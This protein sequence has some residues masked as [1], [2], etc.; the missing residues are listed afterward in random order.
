MKKNVSSVLVPVL[1]FTLT[2]SNVFKASAV[3]AA[4]TPSGAIKYPTVGANIEKDHG[5]ADWTD[6]DLI[7]S[8]DN[9]D[10]KLHSFKHGETSN[11]LK[12]SG[13]GFVIP[14]NA[15]IKGI[16]ATIERQSSGSNIYDNEV[17]LV[18][19]ASGAV[20]TS[21]DKAKTSSWP[22]GSDSSMSYGASTDTWST[23]WTPAQIND[24]SFGLIL[25]V[26]NDDGS[27]NRD[28]YVDTITLAVTYTVPTTGTITVT[29]VVVNDNGGTKTVADFPLK[30]G[31]TSVVSG[32]SKE[33][34]AGTYTVSE[35]GD[36]NYAATFSGDCDAN[37]SI[38]IAAG[39]NKSCTITNDDKPAHLTI[40]KTTVG[41]NGAFEFTISGT[42]SSEH[43]VRTTDG[44]GSTD[45]I[46]MRAG[47]Y[48]VTETS[49]TG[50][51]INSA[52]CTDG[53]SSYS[54]NAVTGIQ[55]PLGAD[56]SC[57]FTNTKRGS[58]TVAKTVLTPGKE[59][60]T[61]DTHPFTVRL[62]GETTKDVSTNSNATFD[63]LLPGTYTITE[64][65]D[66]NYD[67]V[68]ATPDVNPDMLGAQVTIEAGENA[69]VT[70]ENGQKTGNLTVIKNVVNHY[71]VGTALPGSFTME[72]AGTNVAPNNSFAGSETGTTVTMYPGRYSVTEAAGG[73][74]GYSSSFTDG[75]SGEMA[76]NGS[77]TCT[78]TNNDLEPGKGAITVIKDVTNDNGGS[79]KPGDFTLRLTASPDVSIDVQSGAA[80]QLDPNT[81][82]VSEVAKDGYTET[83][84]S[85]TD[86]EE[87]TGGQVTLAA[88]QSYVC[89]VK[90][91][92]VAP[93]L[94]L[95]N[96]VINDNG[97]TTEASAWTLEANGEDAGKLEGA[98][99][100][101]TS[102]GTF[103]AGTYTL[104]AWGG[105]SGYTGTAWT[106]SGGVLNGNEITLTA[107]QNATCEI[108]HNDMSGTLKI[109]KHSDGG[110]GTFNFEINGTG[111]TENRYNVYDL[112]TSE[113][114]NPVTSEEV[115]MDAGAYRITEETQEGWN[116]VSATCTDGDMNA[117]TSTENGVDVYVESGHN[118]TC[119]FEN[120]NHAV[121][122]VKKV[123]V[124]DNGG[125]KI[126]S[127]FSFAIDDGEPV[128]FVVTG[129]N[130]LTGEGRLA[131]TRGVYTVTE[132]PAAGY[133]TSYDGCKNIELGA[134]ESAT[135]TITNND[136][137][138]TP[139]T[140][141]GGGGGF[142]GRI[143]TPPVGG[144]QVLGTSTEAGEIASTS[145]QEG[146]GNATTTATTTAGQVLGASTQCGTYINS[147]MSRKAKNDADDVK[148]LQQFLNETL[149]LKIPLTGNYGLMT[150]SA[151][152][153]FQ[154]AHSDAVL[155]PWV[156]YGLKDDKTAT[157]NVYKMTK[158]RINMLKCPDLG[159]PAPELP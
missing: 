3:V 33:F 25:S 66:V 149:G 75:C 50:W 61:T 6:T 16:T 92:D 65:T 24:A 131:L 31:T 83:S 140:T 98:G 144:G 150:E 79:A 71:G 52:S 107:G 20:A 111:R 11:Y 142:D 4:A 124:N 112:S 135:C 68:S 22:T 84:I 148:K 77:A 97:G 137:A 93:T 120:T 104:S 105:P 44:S 147:F 128:S 62:N 57:T 136:I 42:A 108:T 63:N 36:A 95:I 38:T 117:G 10:A 96:H 30:V 43:S 81:Y 116:F 21:S 26:R 109:V 134:G 23:S 76:S 28:L 86:G 41:G 130:N 154:L 115:T 2:F 37:G 114:E 122:I 48:S 35:T 53:S 88:G 9:H 34:T 99:P 126:A 89:T 127:D 153:Q 14:S 8:S 27:H 12:A 90:N 56:V 103:K 113:A 69:Q 82:V 78:V 67:A 17:R 139:P 87:T 118:L 72:V 143:W 54:G 145:T 155:K 146:S 70:F 19:S 46:E 157:G 119:T 133:E 1:V 47:T 32:T 156:A 158:W 159:L 123:V 5:W 29:K 15:T 58:I 51:D 13:F 138:T 55:I 125:T 91:N 132:T 7:Y 45:P 73:P 49:Q 59:A 18:T 101:V 74:T 106:C 40:N 129:E 60:T 100:T 102:D 141:G 64:D 151:V 152:K 80:N 94:T 85:C 110:W 121:L 39:E